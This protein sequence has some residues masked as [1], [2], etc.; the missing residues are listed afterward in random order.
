MVREPRQSD[1]Y[2]A[3]LVGDLNLASYHRENRSEMWRHLQEENLYPVRVRSIGGGLSSICSF[4]SAP[5]A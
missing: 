2:P 4:V 3:S 1:T 5:C